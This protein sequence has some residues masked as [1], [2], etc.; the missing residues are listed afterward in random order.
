MEF[1]G[2]GQVRGQRSFELK[3]ACLAIDENPLGMIC[4]GECSLQVCSTT[5]VRLCFLGNGPDPDSRLLF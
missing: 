4:G 5:S 2:K 1:H 3:V